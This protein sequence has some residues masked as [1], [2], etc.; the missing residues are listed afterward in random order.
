MIMTQRLR[1]EWWQLAVVSVNKVCRAASIFD[2]ALRALQASRFQAFGHFFEGHVRL[3]V[4]F[5]DARLPVIE[6]DLLPF[7]ARHL[8]Q[9]A[10]GLVEGLGACDVRLED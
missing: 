8:W 9:F 3:V 7:E 5:K 4:F 10:A 2:D 6:I 1:V